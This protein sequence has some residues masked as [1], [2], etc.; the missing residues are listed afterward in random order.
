MTKNFCK[1]LRDCSIYFPCSYFITGFSS[2]PQIQQCQTDFVFDENK[3]MC[4]K[5]Q[6]RD[7]F[8]CLLA[9]NKVSLRSNI[10]ATQTTT[11][12]SNIV[13]HSTL[14]NE[15]ITIYEQSFG[16]S[17]VSNRISLIRKK[18]PMRSFKKYENN[19]TP[20]MHSSLKKKKNVD[21]EYEY[22]GE[23]N[24][25]EENEESED[26]NQPDYKRMCIVT[27]WAQYRK[28]KGQFKFE[29]INIHLCNHI[30][31]STVVVSE[32]EES[33]EED[34]QNE[35]YIIK[36]VQHNDLDLFAKLASFKARKPDLKLILRIGDDNGRLYSKLSKKTETRSNFIKNTLA[37]IK[38]HN[39]DGIEIDWKWP[40][41]Q[42]GSSSDKQNLPLL[43]KVIF[44][45]V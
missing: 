19:F 11:I 17:P 41:G 13:T 12:K 31:F 26:P 14:A 20:K 9:S 15:L 5:P 6:S 25:V 22:E 42:S 37:F 39:F 32:S 24:G 4:V 28:G 2:S 10:N 40:C 1:D 45:K 3:Q 30:I 8:Q 27:D 34:E 29:Y 33:D 38:E 18:S 23:E 7:D 16:A 35:E 36:T 43:L 21:E 44:F